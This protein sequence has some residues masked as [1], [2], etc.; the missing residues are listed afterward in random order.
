V[1]LIFDRALFG[2]G[3]LQKYFYTKEFKNYLLKMIL[4]TKVFGEP[5]LHIS[6][7]K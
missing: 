5:L 6:K 1:G 2:T 4:V 7:K 3:T